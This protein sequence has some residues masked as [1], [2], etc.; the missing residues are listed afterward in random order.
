MLLLVDETHT[1]PLRL[2]EEIRMITNLVREGRPRVRLVMA[3]SPL[4]ELRNAFLFGRVG[5]EPGDRLAACLSAILCE[6]L[7]IPGKQLF[8]AENRKAATTYI[9]DRQGDR[10]TRLQ[11]L[12]HSPAQP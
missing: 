5:D 12:F 11:A 3:G 6:W 10:L 7:A 4:L 8:S 9:L 2:M 1:L